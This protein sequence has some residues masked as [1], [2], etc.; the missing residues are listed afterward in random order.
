MVCCVI[1][2]RVAGGLVRKATVFGGPIAVPA[3]GSA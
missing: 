1:E 3:A 2:W